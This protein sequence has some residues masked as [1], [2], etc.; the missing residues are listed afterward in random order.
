MKTIH[1]TNEAVRTAHFCMEMLAEHNV[2]VSEAIEKMGEEKRAL[3]LQ[4][5][6]AGSDTEIFVERVK[7][8]LYQFVKKVYLHVTFTSY[9]G[10]FCI[11]N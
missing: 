2:N 6:D 3:L 1:F 9:S 8:N 5:N 4:F 7:D 11:R 10:T